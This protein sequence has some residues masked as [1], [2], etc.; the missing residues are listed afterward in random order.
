VVR[1]PLLSYESEREPMVVSR[2]TSVHTNF[3]MK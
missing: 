2:K 3:L 1:L